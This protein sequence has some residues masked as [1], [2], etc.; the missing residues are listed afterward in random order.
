MPEVPHPELLLANDAV[1]DDVQ[2]REIRLAIT[3]ATTTLSTI[4]DEV[5]SLR[6]RIAG[7]TS[8]RTPLES[9]IASQSAIISGVR[10]VPT[11]VLLEIFSYCTNPVYP[12]FHKYN[13]ISKVMQVSSRWRAVALGFPG[14]WRSVILPGGLQIRAEPLLHLVTLQMERTSQSPLSILLRASNTHTLDLLNLV[15]ASSP[16]WRQADI[17]LS[18]VHLDH[19]FS[20]PFPDFGVLTKLSLVINVGSSL[21]TTPAALCPFPSL[22]EL[23]LRMG[24]R[25]V[26]LIFDHVWPSLRHCK[27]EECRSSDVLRVLPLLSKYCQLTLK[28]GDVSHRADE[29]ESVPTT[30]SVSFLSIIMPHGRHG[31]ST[32]YSKLL[33]ALLTAPN[34]QTLSVPATDI[35]IGSTKMFLARSSCPL[36]HLCLQ[37]RDKFDPDSD[38][39]VHF[40]RSPELSE[41]QHLDL[42]L[43]QGWEAQS[44]FTLLLNPETLPCLAILTI[45]HTEVDLTWVRA[46]HSARQTVLRQLGLSPGSVSI[47]KGAGALDGFN[48][49]MCS[50][51]GVADDLVPHWNDLIPTRTRRSAET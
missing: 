46:L 26:P 28:A 51:S 5:S 49:Y 34:L 50:P 11:E 35:F 7:L 12:P 2:V 25:R 10:R 14:L 43:P 47:P 19:I 40:L 1:P 42:N 22:V 18:P 44:L 39:L 38:I 8:Q 15:V 33:D 36:S 37:T 29:H 3:H 48:I 6:Q 9:F 23:T 27:L 31:E 32:F 13:P 21:E 4:D 45:Q 30:S 16:R 41:L 20:D 17:H 24:S